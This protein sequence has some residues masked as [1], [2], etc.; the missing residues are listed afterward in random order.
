MNQKK[1]RSEKNKSIQ[2]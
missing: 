1:S 2:Q